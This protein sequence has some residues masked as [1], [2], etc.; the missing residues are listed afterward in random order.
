MDSD[1]SDNDHKNGHSSDE[2]GRAIDKGA[3]AVNDDSDNDD[4]PSS[5]RVEDGPNN[6]SVIKQ[7]IEDTEQ[8][9]SDN[10]EDD[11]VSD[12][13]EIDQSECSMA[14]DLADSMEQDISEDHP[15]ASS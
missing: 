8:D 4:D 15:C 14:S 1:E 10:D 7:R 12:E 3:A 6:A 5:H 9:Q 2:D 11:Y 13:G